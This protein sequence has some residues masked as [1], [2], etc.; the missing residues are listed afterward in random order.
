M[1]KIERSSIHDGQGLRTVVFFKGCPLDCLWCSTPESKEFD[2]EKG[3][4]PDLC[5]ACGRCV[6]ACP[7]NAIRFSDDHLS[8]QTDKS[9]CKKCFRCFQAC[10][11][12]AVKKYGAFLTVPEV[13]EE[14]KKDEI[15]FFHSKGGITLS[16]GEPLCQAEFA[17]EVLKECRRLGIS[18][19]VE[20]CFHVEYEKIEKILPYL[21]VLLV[22]IKHMDSRRHKNWTGESNALILQNIVRAGRS[23]YPVEIIVRIPLV[24]G[25][26][27]SDENLKHT[28]TFCENL[29][30]LKEIELLAYHR[31]GKDTYRL[32]GKN[33]PGM[34][35]VPPSREQLL[36]RAEFMRKNNPDID[37]KI[38]SGF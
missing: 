13:M 19:A 21:D 36:E 31:L 18:T 20:S 16:G 24:P 12:H 5:T 10:P 4:D 11:S 27:D 30:K 34:D 29:K 3:Y 2:F 9:K 15:F 35:I 23:R 25:Y 28:L 32:L 14:I 33:Y 37:I 17:A 7:E 6:E 1:L 8:V 22:D 26:N 38:S